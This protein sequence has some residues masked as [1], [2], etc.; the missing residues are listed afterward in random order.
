M[1]K[2]VDGRR[3]AADQLPA[4]A[5]LPGRRSYQTAKMGVGHPKEGAKK[6]EPEL[7]RLLYGSPRYA[8]SAA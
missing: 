4:G 8:Y 5:L 7:S 3:T 2:A 6:L 1:G